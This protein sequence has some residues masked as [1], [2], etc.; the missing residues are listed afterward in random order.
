ME[1]DNWG[2]NLYGP[3]KGSRWVSRFLLSYK[4]E[5]YEM[6]EC[7]NFIRSIVDN[8]IVFQ[9][10]IVKDSIHFLVKKRIYIS[11]TN[12]FGYQDHSVQVR[13][14]RTEADFLTL[15]ATLSSQSRQIE[16]THIA[17]QNTYRTIWDIDPLQFSFTKQDEQLLKE[18]ISAVNAIIESY[19]N[20]PLTKREVVAVKPHLPRKRQPRLIIVKQESQ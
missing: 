4:L 16:L 1:L 10:Y 2:E 11:Q 8:P 18:R 20:A 14:I 9:S 19:R 6:Q 3:N 13:E 15:Q 12:Y 5:D 17:A 7:E